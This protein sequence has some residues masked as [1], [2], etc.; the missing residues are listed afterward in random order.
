MTIGTLCLLQLAVGAVID[1]RYDQGILRFYPY[2]VWYP[3]LYWM[4]LA[5]AT[6][7]ALPYLIRRPGHD[8]VTWT[9]QRAGSGS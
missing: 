5:M 1:R 4:F 6:V 9:T 7:I 2:A 8:P 3:I